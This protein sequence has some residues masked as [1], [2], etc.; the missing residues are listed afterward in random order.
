[1]NL[2]GNTNREVLSDNKQ[3]VEK[4]IMR[5]VEI[6]HNYSGDNDYDM[7]RAFVNDLIVELNNSNSSW[8]I[9]A[10][11]YKYLWRGLR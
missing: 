1:M 2:D 6:P 9:Q 3:I 8:R 11:T 7:L 10:L 5:Y 4:S